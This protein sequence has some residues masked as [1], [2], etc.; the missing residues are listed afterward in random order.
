MQVEGKT[1]LWKT[2][3]WQCIT[4][5]IRCISWKCEISQAQFAMFAFWVDMKICWL[6]GWPWGEMCGAKDLWGTKG[7][8]MGA[9]VLMDISRAYQVFKQNWWFGLGHF[10]IKYIKLCLYLRPLALHQP[11][12]KSTARPSDPSTEGD[13]CSLR[14]QSQG[15]HWGTL[16]FGGCSYAQCVDLRSGAQNWE[17][18]GFESSPKNLSP[19]HDP[20]E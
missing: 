5:S 1:T 17:L 13:P 3:N 12:C 10:L 18:G 20:M 11:R 19:C 6:W 9:A 15:G 16:T 7:W 14:D 2:G 4:R 8:G